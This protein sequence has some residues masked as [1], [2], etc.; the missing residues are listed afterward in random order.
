MVQDNW[1]TH[2]RTPSQSPSRVASPS[3]SVASSTEYVRDQ[4]TGEWEVVM[5]WHLETPT[6]EIELVPIGQWRGRPV[7]RDFCPNESTE[8]RAI[9]RLRPIPRPEEQR[10]IADEWR[11]S[12][13]T[14]P[15]LQP[16][17]PSSQSILDSVRNGFA[18]VEQRQQAPPPPPPPTPP[19]TPRRSQ[20]G[21]R[22]TS[23]SGPLNC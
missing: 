11:A 15:G 7:Q 19:T 9:A 17:S 20:R 12:R 18:L 6:K 16:T 1:T 13:S 14:N 3:A 2:P 22:E 8:D 5:D 23:P 21:L 4:S 10:R